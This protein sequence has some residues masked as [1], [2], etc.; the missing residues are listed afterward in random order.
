MAT[1]PM[2]AVAM[3]T[4]TLFAVAHA[5][6]GDSCSVGSYKGA[7]RTTQDCTARGG[8]SVQG[9]C[10]RDPSN[11]MC[12]IDAPCNG[13]TCK[14]NAVAGQCSGS[15]VPG[16]CPGPNNF[17]CCRKTPTD[18]ILG[19]VVGM[20]NTTPE[21]RQ[22]VIEIAGRLRMNPT[23][24]MAVMSFETGGSFSPSKQNTASGATGLIQFMPNTAH[25]LGTTTAALTRMS[26]IQQL[27]YV[28]RFLKPKA[29]LMYTVEDA[30]M[31]VLWPAAVG[32]G[33]DYVIFR[34]PSIYYQQNSGLDTNRDGT[35]TAR[36]AASLVR[37]RIL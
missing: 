9:L 22:K 20:E 10:P 17:Q 36:E 6:I 21:F 37:A 5:A 33:P 15:F 31:A 18:P 27:D 1:M 32:K 28:E 8:G 23:H 25:D 16:L 26:P 4:I 19:R 11:V 2:T 14:N 3:V 30:Y 35:V 13:G 24:L 29:G 34:K 12:C 7:C